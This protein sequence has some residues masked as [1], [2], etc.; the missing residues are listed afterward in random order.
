VNK[1]AEAGAG[2]PDGG[3]AMFVSALLPLRHDNTLQ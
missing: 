3:R 1:G 2:G